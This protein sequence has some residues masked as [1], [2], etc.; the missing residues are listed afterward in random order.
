MDATVTSLNN[1]YGNK[2]DTDVVVDDI[3]FSWDQLLL[4]NYSDIEVL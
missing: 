2:T 3:E 4:D 1:S